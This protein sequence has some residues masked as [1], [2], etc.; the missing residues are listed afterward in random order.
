MTCIEV[1]KIDTNEWEIP[2]TGDMRVPA[3][4]FATD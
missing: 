3:R 2:Q 4:F 1:R